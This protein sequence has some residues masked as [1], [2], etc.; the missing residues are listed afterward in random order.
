MYTHNDIILHCQAVPNPYCTA[1]VLAWCLLA[2]RRPELRMQLAGKRTRGR[3]C[4]QRS[5]APPSSCALQPR[6]FGR[7]L[8]KLMMPPASWDTLAWLMLRVWSP[9]QHATCRF[10]SITHDAA[11]QLGQLALADAWRGLRQHVMRTSF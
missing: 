6:H 4:W 5:I 8:A 1:K 3:Q 11:G 2:A 9:A 10:M 7:T